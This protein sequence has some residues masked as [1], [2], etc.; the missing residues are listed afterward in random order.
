MIFAKLRRLGEV[1]L[2]RLLEVQQLLN[3]GA[4]FHSLE[5]RFAVVKFRQ[6]EFELR[7]AAEAPEEMRI[8]RRE[9]VKEEFAAGKQFVGDGKVLE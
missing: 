1:R 3:T 7:G 4:S 5:M 2:N 8:G 9:V 6:I